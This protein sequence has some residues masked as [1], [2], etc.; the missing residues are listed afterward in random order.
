MKILNKLYK[1]RKLYVLDEKN[2]NLLMKILDND[3]KIYEEYKNDNRTYV[4]K[5]KIGEN[6][7]IL[8]K[9]YPRK[10]IKQLMT[11]F[12]DSESFT[13]LR[14]VEYFRREK[15]IKELVSC[16]GSAEKRK[17]KIVLEEIMLMEF[18]VGNKIKVQEDFL[19]AIESLN[20]L[21][22]NNRFH[23][24][25][26]PNNFI[27]EKE[28][29]EIKIIDTKLKKMWFGNYRMHFDILVL[30]KHIPE[31]LKYPYKKNIFYYLAK[32]VRKIR[33]FKNK[34]I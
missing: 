11:F 29:Q 4:A 27:I 16:L 34:L 6:F 15:G 24:D 12:K 28:T 20:N 9:F 3:Y 1:N 21:Y 5:I 8:K 14:N 13:T 25:C 19:K 31:I 26:N 22:K 33:D 10:K 17:N 23:G 30:M 2:F 7:Y 18:C 32:F